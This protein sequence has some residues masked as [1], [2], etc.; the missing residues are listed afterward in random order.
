M[1]GATALREDAD[2]LKHNF[3]L[4]GYFNK[5]GFA[6][7]PEIRKHSIAQLPAGE[8]VKV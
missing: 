2:A 6:D 5:R 8:P 4:R 1:P 7:P 3:L